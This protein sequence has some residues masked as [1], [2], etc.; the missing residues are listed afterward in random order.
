VHSFASRFTSLIKLS[1]YAGE[2]PFSSAKLAYVHF[3]FEPIK[4]APNLHIKLKGDW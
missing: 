3:S 4:N 1:T 2:K